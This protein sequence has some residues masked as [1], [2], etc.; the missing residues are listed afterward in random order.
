M[1]DYFLGGMNDMA[2][3]TQIVWDKYLVMMQNGTCDSPD[4][5]I[6]ITCTASTPREEGGDLEEPDFNPLYSGNMTRKHFA[7]HKSK[8]LAEIAEHITTERIELKSDGNGAYVTIKG[9]NETVAT[10]EK[11]RSVGAI[12][13]FIGFLWSIVKS[14]IN[15]IV[16]PPAALPWLATIKSKRSNANFGYALRVVDLNGDGASDLIIG[17]PN[18]FRDEATTSKVQGCVFVV[19]G[20]AGNSFPTG[21]IET[22]ASQTVC[23]PTYQYSRFGHSIEVLDSNGD[24]VLDVIVGAPSAGTETLKYHGDVF[25]LLGSTASASYQLGTPTRL[26]TGTPPS[27][28]NRN[29]GWAL[30]V[31]PGTKEYVASSRYYTKTTSSRQVGAVQDI[32]NSQ[33]IE[34]D[35]KYEWFGSSIAYLDA[36]NKLLAVGSP[37]WTDGTKRSLGRVSIYDMATNTKVTE[38][39][40]TEEF[41]QMGFSIAAGTLTIDGSDVKVIYFDK[42]KWKCLI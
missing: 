6:S 12:S 17:A 33:Q 7:E 24:G 5:P 32:D 41:E 42:L 21:Y 14:A 16:P 28:D 13:S 26:T 34:G 29:L 27:S 10:A 37:I 3:W 15:V 8:Y 18:Y 35:V 40:G 36:S 1:E 31:R 2:A 25:L 4:S 30:A 9:I 38:I 23:D 19:L 20:L 11:N 39:K 22:V